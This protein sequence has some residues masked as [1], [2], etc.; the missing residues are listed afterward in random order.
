M[1]IDHI[2]GTSSFLDPVF[3]LPAGEAEVEVEVVEVS[4]QH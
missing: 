4:W 2:V 1:R 3:D